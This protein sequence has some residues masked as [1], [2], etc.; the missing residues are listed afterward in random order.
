MYL[1]YGLIIRILTSIGKYV[2]LRSQFNNL[3]SSVVKMCHC[4]QNISQYRSISSNYSGGENE[5]QRRQTDGY[6]GR[7]YS[8]GK[9]AV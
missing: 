7:Q 9:T 2:D 8:K 6:M 1:K 5:W 3:A 4:G